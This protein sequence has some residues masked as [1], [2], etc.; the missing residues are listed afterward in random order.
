ML[1]M[2]PPPFGAVGRRTAANSP[3]RRPLTLRRQGRAG[4]QPKTLGRAWTL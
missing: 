2:E 3:E 4:R 1:G